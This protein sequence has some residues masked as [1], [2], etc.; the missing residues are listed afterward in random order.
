[1]S[2]WSR[3]LRDKDAWLGMPDQFR[4][5]NLAIQAI[6]G[7][8]VS[9]CCKYELEFKLYEG[10][11]FYFYLILDD[12]VMGQQAIV[13]NRIIQSTRQTP[14]CWTPKGSVMSVFMA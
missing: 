5:H 11:K 12:S 1:M 6:R 3:L 10:M 4:T 14:V 2:E 9:L 13:A 7:L 8:V